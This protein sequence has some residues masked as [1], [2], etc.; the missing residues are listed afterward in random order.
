MA[1]AM[2]G[3]RGRAGVAVFTGLECTWEDAAIWRWVVGGGWLQ[4]N[5]SAL[6]TPELCTGKWGGGRCLCYVHFIAMKTVS[7]AKGRGRKGESVRCS[8]CR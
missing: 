3:R 7:C 1:A 4:N 8:E 5:V 6:T 2:A